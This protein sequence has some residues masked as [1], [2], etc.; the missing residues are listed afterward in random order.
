MVKK[1][2]QATPHTKLTNRLNRITA[3]FISPN[4]TSTPAIKINPR[5]ALTDLVSHQRA[6][7]EV[8]ELKA[9]IKT[10]KRIH[11]EEVLEMR[12]QTNKFI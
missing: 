11:M 8:K 5:Q 9:T 7:E 1:K 2:N 3:K 4:S 6:V 10:M 12:R